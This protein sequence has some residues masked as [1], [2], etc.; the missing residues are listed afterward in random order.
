MTES[1]KQ[2]L[3]ERARLDGIDLSGLNTRALGI[4]AR[5]Y[6][7]ID[8]R[9]ALL[10][11]TEINIAS[12][13]KAIGISRT[14]TASNAVFNGIINAN[15]TILPESV[16]ARKVKEMERELRSLR[17]WHDCAMVTELERMEMARENEDLKS[18]LMSSQASFTIEHKK[19][20]EAMQENKAL[21]VQLEEANAAL[22]ALVTWEKK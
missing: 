15:R 1:E 6:G 16:D 18:R 14:N 8:R 11:E 21:R 4:A 9:K 3:F 10:P 12:I 17:N 19:Y 5:I 20:E 22:A 7:E 13:C 2:T